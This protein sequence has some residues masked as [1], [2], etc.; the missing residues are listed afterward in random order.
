[1]P[2]S[3]DCAPQQDALE[4]AWLTPDEASGTDV[5]AEM[6]DGHGVILRQALAHL[7]FPV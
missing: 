7:G 3:G 4:L 6:V 2:V 5:A 1:M